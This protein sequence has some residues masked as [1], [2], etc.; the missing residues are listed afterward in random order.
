MN[1]CK[2]QYELVYAKKYKL[3]YAKKYKLVYNPSYKKRLMG[4]FE[5]IKSLVND[6]FAAV[7]ASPTVDT[8]AMDPPARNPLTMDPSFSDLPFNDPEVIVNDVVK[9][10]TTL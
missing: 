6:K 5:K 9:L 1:K 3:M 7:L 2:L 8:Y 4:S 10:N